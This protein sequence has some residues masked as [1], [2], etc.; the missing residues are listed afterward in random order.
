MRKKIILG[1]LVACLFAFVAVFAF[2]QSGSNVRWE[3]SVQRGINQT[4][5]NQLGAE[6][7]ELVAVDGHG[8]SNAPAWVFKR[9]LP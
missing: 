2:A 9:R 3:Y 5:A 1:A 8:V 4:T 7:W 6:G